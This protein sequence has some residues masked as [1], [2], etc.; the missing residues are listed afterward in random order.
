ML[1]KQE[2]MRKRLKQG[3]LP[4]MAQPIDDK[5]NPYLVVD[6]QSLEVGMVGLNEMT[7]F[8][9]GE[10]LHESDAAWT[11]GL[12]IMGEMK[13]IAAEL[14]NDTG[15]FF[16]LSRTPAESSSYRMAR[17]DMRHY[18]DAI[19][20]GDAKS[21]AV[22]YTN[23]F[24]I[25]PSADVSLVTRIQREAAFHPLMDGGAMSHIWLGEGTPDPDAILK[26]TERIATKTLMG[27]FAYT[28]DLTLC[29]EC[30]FTAGGMLK[31]C[32]KCGSSNV[33]WYSR[34]T[35]YYQRV[36]SWN[37]GKQQ[38]LKDRKRYNVAKDGVF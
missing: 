26:L 4:F 32:P 25:R 37:K 21:N 19:V 18:P 34:I 20:Q 14:R 33:D 24:H 22:Y 35:G 13:K 6:K 10:E 12:K 17:V 7:Q 30:L 27:Y 31:T 29:S 3:L 38:E 15:F 8:H 23:S 1:I 28:K 9:T 16:G 36:S 2:L 5:K 11:F